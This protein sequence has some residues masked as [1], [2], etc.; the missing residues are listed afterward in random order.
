M[1]YNTRRGPVNV[2]LRY[3]QFT[4]F[5]SPLPARAI[6]KML[7]QKIYKAAHLGRQPQLLRVQRPDIGRRAVPARQY[8]LQAAAVQVGG[9]VP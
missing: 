3:V 9:Y 5:C 7:A 4:L 6:G 1:P 8:T 2:G